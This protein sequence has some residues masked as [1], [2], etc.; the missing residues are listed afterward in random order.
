[1]LNR[2]LSTRIACILLI[3]HGAIEIAGLVLIKSIPQTLINFGGLT[4][5]SLEQNTVTIAIFGAFWG[6]ARMIA[7][8]GA[9]SLRK[10]ALVLGILMSAVTMS[11]AITIVPA[12]VGDTFFSVSIL[13][14]L[15]YA[16]F[17]NEVK[18]M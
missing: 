15:L 12:G 1:M 14:L 5:A 8:I 16:W 18:E 9:W 2:K 13:I 6:V 11:A 10:W 3:L 4:G 17:G 7:A